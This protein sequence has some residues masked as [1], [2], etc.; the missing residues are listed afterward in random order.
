MPMIEQH[1]YSGIEFFGGSVR[2]RTAA[3][4]IFLFLQALRGD[5]VN[6]GKNQHQRKSGRQQQKNQPSCIDGQAKQGNA[7]I[8]HLQDNPAGHHVK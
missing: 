6:P 2:Y 5:L 8:G 4:N 3:I 7:Y 1:D